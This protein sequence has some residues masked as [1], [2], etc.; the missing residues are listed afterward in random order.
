MRPVRVSP[1][2]G[3]DASADE[4]K[5]YLNFI[6]ILE[7]SVVAGNYREAYEYCNKVLEL[8]PHSAEILESK[9]ICAHRLSTKRDLV[10]DEAREVVTCLDA[11][12]RYNPESETLSKTSSNTGWSVYLLGCFWLHAETPDEVI[13]NRPVFSDALVRRML[14]YIQ[15]LNVAF[16]VCGETKFLKDAVT[17]LSGY[18]KVHLPG[19]AQKV[20]AA[21]LRNTCIAKIKRVEPSYTPPGIH[22][23]QSG[24]SDGNS[25]AFSILLIAILFIFVYIYEEFRR[26]KPA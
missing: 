7:N 9:A 20:P 25:L 13:N 10:E 16:D 4:R 8:D 1:S 15:L 12:R 26:Y 2:S 14:K 3:V 6:T 5:R 23:P 22:V 21:N 24:C 19:G 17:E 11:A 18:G